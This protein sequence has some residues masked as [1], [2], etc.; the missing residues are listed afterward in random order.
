MKPVLGIESSHRLL[1]LRCLLLFGLFLNGSTI[2]ADTEGL[3]LLIEK[4]LQDEQTFEPKS[5]SVVPPK[6]LREQL[7][8]EKKSIR[9]REIGPLQI[10]VKKA[11]ASDDQPEPAQ[12]VTINMLKEAGAQVSIADIRKRALQNNLALRVIEYDPVIAKTIVREEEAKFDNILFAYATRVNQDLP[13]YSSDRVEFKSNNPALSG[14]QLRLSLLEQERRR[15]FLDA[16]IKVPLRTGGTV[17]VSSP[18]SNK[19]SSGDFASREYQSALQFSF[20]QPLLRNAGSRVNEASIEIA[21]YDY[22]AAQLKARLQSIRVVAMVDKAY[23]ELYQAWGN[24]DVSRQQYEYANQN[25]AMV[26]RRVDEGLTAAI[27]LNRAEIGVADR[28][29]TLI[30]AET[31]LKLAVRQLQFLMNDIDPASEVML[32][33]TTSPDLLWFEFDKQKLLNDAM[34]GRIELLEQEVKLTAD[35][36]KIDYLENQTL[37]LFTLDYQYGAL[38]NTFNSMGDTYRGVLN[39]Q[40][41]DWSLGLK[42]EMPWTNEA[43]KAQLENAVQQRMQRLTT[44]DLQALTVKREIFDALDKVDQNWRRILAAR[45]QVLIAGIN[46]Q[47]E[48]KQFY[49]GL[50]T[51]TEVLETLT[52]LGEAQVKEVR[53]IT[54]YQI[55]LIDTAYATGTLL[56]YSK[57]QFQPVQQ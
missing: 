14:Q 51:M 15:A 10:D 34:S 47:A 29:D 5:K 23:W 9:A 7:E 11:L 31:N 52:R 49:E 25:L 32:I 45:Q 17:T 40:F 53:A 39:G 16:G 46:Y 1:M 26:K 20:S 43:R 30:V 56:G 27:E 24:L 35:L 8:D 57:I 37:P 2:S 12:G 42:F 21:S 33:P 3:P 44:R 48:L 36:V 54:D 50:R 13:T 38:S 22:K 19:V 28:L 18:L 4:R 41:S 6:T 55:S